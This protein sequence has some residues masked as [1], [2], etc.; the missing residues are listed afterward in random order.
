MWYGGRLFR[1]VESSETGQVNSETIFKYE[2]TGE[3]VTATYSGGNIRFGQIIGQVDED[4]ILDMRY[5]HIDREG[6]LMTGYCT[7]TPEV[8]PSGK[9]RTPCKGP[10]YL[11]RNLMW[12]RRN[13]AFGFRMFH[14]MR[15]KIENNFDDHKQ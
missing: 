13:Q 5:Q 2:Q 1:S 9:V 6:E 10:Q 11:R 8:L 7:T 3:M 12:R 15:G 14:N 4:G